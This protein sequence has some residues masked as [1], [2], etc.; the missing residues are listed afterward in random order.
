MKRR[1]F[2][3]VELVVVVAIIGILAAM[4]TPNIGGMMEKARN[5]RAQADVNAVTT[6]MYAL[7]NDTSYVSGERPAWQG[8]TSGRGLNGPNYGIIQTNGSY[9][10]WNGPYMRRAIG[11]DPWNR[12]Y[13]YDGGDAGE[14]DCSGCASFA[15]AGRNGTHQS[16]NR[17]DLTPQGDDII[18]YLK[19]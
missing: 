1:S 16:F 9:P 18:I 19:R 13:Y 6:A 8:D 3:L 4:L 17:T 5:A 11:L 10:N 7:L 2:T 15:S 14:W 12:D